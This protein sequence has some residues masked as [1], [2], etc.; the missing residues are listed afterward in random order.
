MKVNSQPDVRPVDRRVVSDD[1]IGSLPE[2]LHPV[3]RRV[4]AARGI[5]PESV[6]LS[7]QNMLPISSLEGTSAAAERLLDAHKN[8][9]RVVVVGDFDADGATATALVMTCLRAFGFASPDYLVPDRQ[10][11]GYGL[12]AGI[13]A[14]A[15]QMQPDVLV[16]VDNGISSHAGVTA[17]QQLGIDVIITDH[18]LPGETLPAAQVTV[19]PNAPD[20]Q[21]PSK[22]LAGVGV[23]FYVMAALGQRLAK[24]GL[25]ASDTARSVC[26]DCLDLV[27][28]GTV[29]DLVPLDWNNRIL[30]AQGLNRMRRRGSRPGIEALFEVAGRNIAYAATSDLG[31]A[32]GPRLNAAGRLD[33]MSIGIECLLAEDAVQARS[34]ATRLSN[35]N[36]ERRELQAKMQKDA[37]VHLEKLQEMLSTETTGAICLFDESWHQGVVGLVATRIKDLLN[38]PVVAFALGDDGELLKGSGRSVSGVHL[39]DVLATIDAR[40]PGLIEKFGG[41]AM[42]AGLS[43]PL[44][45]LEEFRAAFAAEVDRYAAEID[46]SGTL[47]TDGALE[48]QDLNLGFAEL[49]RDSGPWGQGFPE[50]LFEGEFTVLEQ[51]I[52]GEHHLKLRVQQIDSGIP[53]DAIAFNHDELIASQQSGSVRLVY[54]LDVNEFRQTRRQQLVVEHLESV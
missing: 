16:T 41:H 14:V 46:D 19:N 28:L 1:L 26:A 50:P 11:F 22:S 32:I 42:A 18:H 5:Q 25:L 31:F 6:D 27:A 7:L 24:E 51:R 43:L 34:L 33:D 36:D 29:A 40:K 21:F 39:R 30:V 9:Q 15:A 20:S 4:Y 47:L 38:R 10:K 2:S 8:A 53:I 35:L 12:T 13:V 48:S 44:V 45:H 17:A 3:I 54:R 52:V 49:L 37:E 23:A